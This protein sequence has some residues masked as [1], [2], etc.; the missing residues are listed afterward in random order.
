[1]KLDVEG[2]ECEVICATPAAA[3][4]GVDELFVEHHDF[5]PCSTEQLAQHLARAG[6]ALRETRE[7]EVLLFTR[8]AETVRARP[9]E[10]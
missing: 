4:T 3:W 1:M 8:E 6:L 7:G 2:A 9:A 5:A 10:R